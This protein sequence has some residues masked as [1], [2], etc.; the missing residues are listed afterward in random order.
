MYVN[1]SFLIDGFPIYG[2]VFALNVMT[3]MLNANQSLKVDVFDLTVTV[4]S[5]FT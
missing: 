2:K 1:I 4:G 5:S 3:T